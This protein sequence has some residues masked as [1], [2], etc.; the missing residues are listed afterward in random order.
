MSTHAGPEENL[1][2]YVLLQSL[3]VSLLHASELLCDIT[4]VFHYKNHMWMCPGNEREVY[5]CTCT[6]SNVYMYVRVFM[7]ISL[8]CSKEKGL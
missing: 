6:C 7:L 8:G 5:I 3:I 4:Y 2:R 1:D